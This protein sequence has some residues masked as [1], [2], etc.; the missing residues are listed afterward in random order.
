MKEVK[1]LLLFFGGAAF[2]GFWWLFSTFK[3]ESLFWLA[4]AF[5][6]GL[7][8][9]AGR[10]CYYH[11]DDHRIAF[12]QDSLDSLLSMIGTGNPVLSRHASTPSMDEVLYSKNN[13]ILEAVHE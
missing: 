5:T 12:N 4:A 1:I 3:L 8:Y 6:L 7:T 10:Y 13:E 2:V 9:L 11:W